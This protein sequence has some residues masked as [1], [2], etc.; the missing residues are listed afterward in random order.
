AHLLERADQRAHLIVQEGARG[1]ADLDLLAKA[2]DLQLVEGLHRAFRLALDRTEGGEVVPAYE[3][4]RGLVHGLGVEPSRHMPHLAAIQRRR[5]AA[6]E[7]AVEIMPRLGREARI[8]ILWYGS[9]T[10]NG[11]RL[12]NHSQMGV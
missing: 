9:S 12:A 4:L 11:D 5:R 7:D 1:G 3:P 8:E 10:K 6:V 2:R